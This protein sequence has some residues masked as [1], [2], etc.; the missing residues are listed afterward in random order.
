MYY[1]AKMYAFDYCYCNNYYIFEKKITN[2]YETYYYR[3]VIV[4]VSKMEY[5]KLWIQ[6]LTQY[7]G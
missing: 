5:A 1:I 3:G 2:Y 7:R 6:L 4:F